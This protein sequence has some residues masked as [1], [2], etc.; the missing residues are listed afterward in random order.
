ML[1]RIATWISVQLLGRKVAICSLQIE[2]VFTV[3]FGEGIIE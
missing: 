3:S 2:Q 1:G